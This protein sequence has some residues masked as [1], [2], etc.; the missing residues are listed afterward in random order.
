MSKRILSF[1]LILLASAI[2]QALSAATAVPGELSGWEAWVL[3]GQEYR[4]CP[5]MGPSEGGDENSFRCL[6]PERLAISVNAHG[7]TFTQRWQVFAESWI[8]LPGSL[9]HWPR[10]VRSNGAPLAIVA[11]DGLPQARLAPGTY[12]IS[13]TFE[14][15]Q[16]PEALTIAGETALVDLSI[17]GQRVA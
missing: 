6:W 4:R 13:G 3:K 16:R 5:L 8:T 14:S 11:R 7:G 17:D 1:A 9:E 2:P 10:D 12:S 15:S